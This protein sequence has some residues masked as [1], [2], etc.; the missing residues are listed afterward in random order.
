MVALGVKRKWRCRSHTICS[1]LPAALWTIK[2][3]N[4][5]RFIVCDLRGKA[6]RQAARTGPSR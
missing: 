6:V 1:P 4:D 5:N 3:D 2:E